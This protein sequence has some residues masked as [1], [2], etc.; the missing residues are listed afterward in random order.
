MSIYYPSRR[1]FLETAA[2]TAIAAPVMLRAQSG[3]FHS[4]VKI[5]PD[6]TIGQID[7]N[8]YGNFVEH[9]GRCIEGGIFQEGSSLSDSNGYRTDVMKAVKDLNVSLLRWPGG[10]F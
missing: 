4:R 10:N 8:I 5:D 2:K 1:T 9:L 3:S 6:R 7:P